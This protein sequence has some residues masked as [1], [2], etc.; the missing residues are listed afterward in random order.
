MQFDRVTVLAPGWWALTGRPPPPPDAP[1]PRALKARERA[2]E[3]Y[4]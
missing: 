1:T 2:A 4:L 3:R